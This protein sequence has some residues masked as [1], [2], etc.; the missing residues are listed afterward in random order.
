MSDMQRHLDVGS[1]MVILV[2]FALFVAAIFI[3]G[4][5][6]DL[7][8]EAGVFLVSLKL[9]MMAYKNSVGARQLNQRLDDVHAKLTRMEEL[10]ESRL[11]SEPAMGPPNKA[12]QPAGAADQPENAKGAGRARG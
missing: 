11:V 6:H 7:L 1:R 5:G 8:L 9:I 2:T 3:K 4:I 10:L 12:L